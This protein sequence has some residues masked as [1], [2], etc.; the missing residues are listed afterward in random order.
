MTRVEFRLAMPGRSSW[1]GKWS[2]DDRNLTLERKLDDEKATQLDGRTWSY[3]WPDGWRAE[4]S[5]RVIRV[6][7]RE[8]PSSGFHGYDWMVASIL[9]HGRIYADHEVPTVDP[10]VV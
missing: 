9:R 8:V 10:A 5:A 1:D 6:E 7:E 2:G 3:G 4:V